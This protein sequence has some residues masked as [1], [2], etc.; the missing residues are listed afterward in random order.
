MVLSNDGMWVDIYLPSYTGFVLKS[1]YASTIADGSNGWH[2]YKFEQWFGD[3]GKKLIR[4]TEFVTASIGSN[5]GTNITGS[6]DPGTTGGHNDTAGRRMISNIGCE[7]M[8]GAL[9]QGSRDTGG[10]TSSAAWANAFD[11]NDSGVAGQQYAAP[12]R[13]RLGG[14]WNDG[15]RCGSRASDWNSSPLALNSY[16]SARG[17]AEPAANRL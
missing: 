1:T 8:A 11:A 13:A 2:G 16:A 7:D 6:A 17:V 14:L 3:I 12:Y 9:R 5:Q 15:S 10:L 4:Q